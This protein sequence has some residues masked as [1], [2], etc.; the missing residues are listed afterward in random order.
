MNERELE[1][2]LPTVEEL[3]AMSLEGFREWTTKAKYEIKERKIK[4]DPL[5]HVKR[6]ILLIL[7]TKLMDD[8]VKEHLIYKSI[9]D[10]DS[11]Y[12]K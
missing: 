3:E 12:R 4:R 5:P 1:T 2:F 9:R 11:N 10:Y 6:E 7:N 8:E